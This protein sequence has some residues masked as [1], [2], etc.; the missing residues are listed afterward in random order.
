MPERLVNLALSTGTIERLSD[1]VLLMIFRHY[2][3]E[4]PRFWPMLVRIC[5]KWRRVVFASQEALHLRLFCT[6]GTPVLK[7]LD[8]WPA[9]PIVIEYGGSLELDSPS[10][11]DEVNI[12][13]ALKQSDRI[14]SIRLTVT[15][16]L[17]ERL[18]AIERPFFELRD[19]ILL[20]RESVPLTL[21][22]A[23][24]WGPRLRC[25][26][27]NGIT[28]PTLH[29]LLHSSRNL[30]DLQ[31]REGEGPWYFSI[32]E[33][34]DALSETAQLRSLSLHFPS[35]TD[36][37]FPYHPQPNR[38][39]IFPALI[40]LHFRGISESLERLVLRVDAPRL[41]D[42]QITLLDKSIF[43]LSSLGKFIDRIKIFKSHHQ[44]R[45]LSSDDAISIS[46]ARP[47]APSCLKLQLFSEVLSEHC[48]LSAL[49]RILPY[50][51]VFLNVEDLHITVTKRSSPDDSHRS[52]RWVEILSSFTGVKW[53]HLDGA[54]STNV[55]QGAELLDKTVLPAL[56]KL[57]LPHPGPCHAPLSEAIVSFMTSHW[58]SGYP[59]GVEY[60]CLCRISELNANGAG[61]SVVKKRS[62]IG[63]LLCTSPLHYVLIC[64]KQDY[65]W[66]RS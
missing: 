34:M 6:P 42:V 38:R 58:R 25:L 40:S 35:T 45:I 41:R 19:L 49:L 2:L 50:F 37:I 8:C 66:S 46:S 26:H 3:D 56:H 57:Y 15:T 28:V 60:E 54:D 7:N 22:G 9:L 64:L 16:S 44:A 36:Y 63:K 23:F 55:F 18:F 52:G 53:L 65:F 62:K 5:R 61:T 4:C 29:Q 39:V 10:P 24:R 47:G 31:L 43:Y 30:V 21:P 17:L 48:Q 1:D 32:E 20:S 13:A 12:I 27:L 14:R 59:I 11:E 33:L 51:P